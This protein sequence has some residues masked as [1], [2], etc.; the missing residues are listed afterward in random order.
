[1]AILHF[2]LHY[3]TDFFLIYCSLGIPKALSVTK[4]MVCWNSFIVLLIWAESSSGFVS[5]S[6]S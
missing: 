2:S 1:M 5:F 3:G 6:V 4:V